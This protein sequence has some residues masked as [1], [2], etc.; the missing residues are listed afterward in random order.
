MYN[1][2]ENILFSRLQL[3]QLVEF[4]VQGD[5]NCQVIVLIYPLQSTLT[6]VPHF[7]WNCD[8]YITEALFI[9]IYIVI[10]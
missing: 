4:K 2:A 5:G 9:Y 3:Y 10:G 1:R 8:A 6:S 7:P